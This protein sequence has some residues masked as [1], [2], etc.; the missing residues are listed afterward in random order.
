LYQNLRVL[1]KSL[2]LRGLLARL[3][4]RSLLR[5]SLLRDVPPTGCPSYGMSLLRDP[6]GTYGIS[7]TV[8]RDLLPSGTYGIS[9]PSGST[10]Y[11]HPVLPLSRRTLSCVYSVR[12]ERERRCSRVEKGQ[13]SRAVKGCG[14]G[15]GLRAPK[16]AESPR[17]G[18]EAASA[19]S[20]ALPPRTHRRCVLSHQ[21]RGGVQGAVSEERAKGQGLSRAR[22]RA[23]KAAES[24]RKGEEAASAASVALPSG[25]H[26]RCVCLCE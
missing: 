1:S 5:D 19:A 21:R 9:S 25:T 11:H 18:E 12:G 7:P 3:Y 8:L 15:L 22:A 17:K 6:Y 23:P 26:R 4:L 13:G 10:P 20:V 24:R 2:S 14:Q 16:A